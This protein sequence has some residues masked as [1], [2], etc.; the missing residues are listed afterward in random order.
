MRFIGPIERR[1][2][3]IEMRLGKK[4]RKTGTDD[5]AAKITEFRKAVEARRAHRDAAPGT[6]TERMAEEYLATVDRHEARERG[7]SSSGGPDA[8]EIDGSGD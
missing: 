6:E 4:K 1:I 2:D 5:P 8:T 3:R 7:G